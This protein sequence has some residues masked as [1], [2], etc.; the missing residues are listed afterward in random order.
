MRRK[1]PFFYKP[2][3]H[4]DSFLTEAQSNSEMAY[5]N[6]SNSYQ[7]HQLGHQQLHIYL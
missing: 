2:A 7:C 4:K 3:L 1:K 6:N 5:Q